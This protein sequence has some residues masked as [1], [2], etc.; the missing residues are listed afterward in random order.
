MKE[1]TW[2]TFLPIEGITLARELPEAHFGNFKL[3]RLKNE[4]RYDD[5]VAQVNHEHSLHCL[6][7]S[8]SLTG[9]PA[10]PPLCDD[11]PKQAKETF[12]KHC[13]CLRPKQN[14]KELLNA[15]ETSLGIM[16]DVTALLRFYLYVSCQGRW[17]V[18]NL[19]DARHLP[20]Y[21][22]IPSLSSAGEIEI[23]SFHPGLRG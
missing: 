9:T 21:G 5:I 2:R 23:T 1:K 14:P 19:I 8:H 4:G 13:L 7:L 22:V 10:E 18:M 20:V 16:R 15:T 3:S 17:P 11:C 12:L 6:C